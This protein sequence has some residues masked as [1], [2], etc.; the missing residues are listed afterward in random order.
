MYAKYKQAGFSAALA[1]IVN[2]F[3]IGATTSWQLDWEWENVTKGKKVG[4]TVVADINKGK[5]EEEDNDEDAMLEDMPFAC[6]I[7]KGLYRNQSSQDVG[8][9]SVSRVRRKI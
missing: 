3:M 4:G 9:T 8:I 1:R 6:I 7:C 2:S 5:V